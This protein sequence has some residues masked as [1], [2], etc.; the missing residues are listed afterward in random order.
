MKLPKFECPGHFV[1]Y[2]ARN[3]AIARGLKG[4]QK[5]DCEYVAEQI[6]LIYGN[7]KAM[8]PIEHFRPNFPQSLLLYQLNGQGQ[9]PRVLM[10]EGANKTGKSTL[11]V[12]WQIAMACGQFPW[13]NPK[14]QYNFVD[15]GKYWHFDFSKRWREYRKIN[16]YLG[17]SSYNELSDK[18]FDLKRLCPKLQVPNVNIALGETYTESVDKDLV[19]KYISEIDGMIPKRWKPKS[20]KNQQGIVARIKLE[21]GPGRGSLFH[22][23]SYKSPSEEFEGIDASGSI[24]FNEPPPQDI[25]TAVNRG[26]LPKDTR[27]LYAYTALKEAWLYRD[28]VNR[29]SRWL[30]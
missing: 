13:L 16:E 22:F 30:V 3:P 1:E 27:A 8:S 23:R 15:G 26:A 19:P 2:F 20:K 29:A 18:F 24:L 17:F 28:Y 10:L 25:V 14:L 9:M 4:Q 6:D 21:R 11:G 7:N 5:K 12:A